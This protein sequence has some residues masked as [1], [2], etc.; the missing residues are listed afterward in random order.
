L[1]G[2]LPKGRKTRGLGKNKN[3]ATLKTANVARK[4]KRKKDR[5]KRKKEREERKKARAEAEKKAK[6]KKAREKLADADWKQLKEEIEAL[7]A[8]YRPDGVTE[9]ELKKE[10]ARIRGRY[11]NVAGRGKVRGIEG[12]WSV[13]VHRKGKR[14]KAE[15]KVLMTVAQRHKDVA[16]KL[17]R[18]LD[19]LDKDERTRAKIQRIAEGFK[20]DYGIDAIEVVEPK[21]DGDPFIINGTF[22]GK[23]LKIGE[24]DVITDHHTGT[25]Y[26]P[27]PIYWYKEKS[28]YPPSID[29]QIDGKTKAVKMNDTATFITHD[30]KK[31]R[32]GVTANNMVEKYRD[33]TRRLAPPRVNEEK[34]YSALKAHGYDMAAQKPR[35]SP[36][37]VTDLGMSGP[38]A[39]DNLWPL[40]SK[41][42]EIGFGWMRDYQIEFLSG[43]Q[44]V[45]SNILSKTMVGKNFRVM[46][47]D[48]K[49]KMP[50]GKGTNRSPARK[51][52]RGK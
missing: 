37:H 25:K 10:V 11:P 7:E 33:L 29:L 42:N 18:K 26:D 2:L 3:K 13:E 17:R 36:D 47:F 23:K 32:V 22:A 51:A 27:I 28:D 9:S 38:D 44:I 21:K 16:N 49:P 15:V 45:T 6:D 48:K 41:I 4:E 12:R 34:Y 19:A 40:D 30:S 50:G 43:G 35:E 8:K 24:T 14:G 52:G 46:G 39:F 5:E 20:K 31:V 1:L